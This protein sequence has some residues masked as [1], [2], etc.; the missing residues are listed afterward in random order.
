MTHRLYT[1]Q[2]GYDRRAIRLRA[3]ALYAKALARGDDGDASAFSYWL[4]YSWRVA[5]GQKDASRWAM[6]EAAARSAAAF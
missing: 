2:G 5:R 1:L 4:K 3:L 6:V